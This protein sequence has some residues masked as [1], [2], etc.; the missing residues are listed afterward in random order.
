MPSIVGRF[1][2]PFDVYLL[3]NDCA[4]KNSK[5]VIT[6]LPITHKDITW[7]ISIFKANN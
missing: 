6:D 1:S 2:Y 5:T 3:K 4:Y 7:V